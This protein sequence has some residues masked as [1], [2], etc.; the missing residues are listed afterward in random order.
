MITYSVE[1]T[2]DGAR[3]TAAC[4]DCADKLPADETTYSRK[5]FIRKLTG[6]ADFLKSQR[7]RQ[8]SRDWSV[9][10]SLPVDFYQVN[11]DAEVTEA[12]LYN[13]MGSYLRYM[14]L[15]SSQNESSYKTQRQGFFDFIKNHLSHRYAIGMIPPL[16][17][18]AADNQPLLAPT[19][20]FNAD[21]QN[22]R[23]SE[24]VIPNTSKFT[25][26]GNGEYKFRDN[27]TYKFP[28]WKIEMLFQK[29]SSWP[30]DDREIIER[31]GSNCDPRRWKGAADYWG[32]WL[33]PAQYP[34]DNPSQVTDMSGS[35]TDTDWQ[36]LI[37]ASNNVGTL[38]THKVLRNNETL[39]ITNPAHYSTLWSPNEA[40]LPNGDPD[41]DYYFDPGHQRTDIG[42]GL[43]YQYQ[44]QVLVKAEGDVQVDGQTLHCGPYYYTDIFYV[45]MYATEKTV[46]KTL[47]LAREA[48]GERYNFTY[49]NDNSNPGYRPVTP[50]DETLSLFP[51]SQGTPDKLETPKAVY[52]SA[53]MDFKPNL[54]ENYSDTA[55]VFYKTGP[56]TQAL[57]RFPNKDVTVP[58]LTPADRTE[59]GFATWLNQWYPNFAIY[60]PPIDV[61]G[62]VRGPWVVNLTTREGWRGDPFP[63]GPDEPV[64]GMKNDQGQ[65]ITW[66]DA[67][68][69]KPT[70]FGGDLAKT[71]YYLYESSQA[72]VMTNYNSAAVPGGYK[73][74]INGVCW[75]GHPVFQIPAEKS[76]YTLLA[77]ALPIP[78]GYQTVH[79]TV[80]TGG[81]STKLVAGADVMLQDRMP[82]SAEELKQNEA[83][84]LVPKMRDNYAYS[85]V[86]ISAGC[87][88]TVTKTLIDKKVAVAFQPRPGLSVTLTDK[89]SRAEASSGGAGGSAQAACETLGLWQGGNT[90][91]G[92]SPLPYD[93]MS[94]DSRIPDGYQYGGYQNNYTTMAYNS[95]PNGAPAGLLTDAKGK[96]P[97]ESQLTYYANQAYDVQISA[98]P[99]TGPTM[100][101][102][103]PAGDVDGKHYIYYCAKELKATI[104]RVEPGKEEVIKE[105]NLL[106]PP[107]QTGMFANLNTE[108]PIGV[109]NMVWPK[110]GD[111]E[112]RVQFKD[113]NDLA[114]N[115]TTHVK[116]I[117][118]GFAPEQKGEE[119]ERKN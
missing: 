72:T 31:A 21:K 66:K 71:V 113:C 57:I 4:P 86:T 80:N 2:Y 67:G 41:N 84:K 20:I 19:D 74:A 76:N 38:Y 77:G 8:Y 105:F 82:V 63:Y 78:V 11:S 85:A 81:A 100:T 50:P 91:T 52:P 54:P 7:V 79:G 9:I 14:D 32:W 59:T 10:N 45:D 95:L 108:P 3:N 117:D 26:L 93:A 56:D 89:Q 104:V 23:D 87:C 116:V 114:R 53:E 15:S 98:E 73:T 33:S 44:C 36:G 55:A 16:F 30:Q 61:G 111:Y 18:K 43:W 46:P 49:E 64:P 69:F 24:F 92:V 65:A 27:K 1:T 47:A 35:F 99:A 48:Y 96:N 90:S 42:H 119:R 6:D 97:L 51:N 70:R 34:S 13:Y 115:V 83:E 17:M 28:N 39:D 110:K 62:A 75:D 68:V 107:L 29:R 40:R 60:Y 103:N 112:I 12:L 102:K 106:T 109:V 118:K 25:N 58:N 37:T 88:G 94:A 22:A 5:V 101:D